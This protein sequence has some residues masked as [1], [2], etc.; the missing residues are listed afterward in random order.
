MYINRRVRPAG[1]QDEAIFHTRWGRFGVPPFSPSQWLPASPSAFRLEI[2][3]FTKDWDVLRK[4]LDKIDNAI[5]HV[6]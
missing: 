5:E 3:R 1:A 6:K 2:L 4:G